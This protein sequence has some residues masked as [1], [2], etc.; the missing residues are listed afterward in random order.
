MCNLESTT[1][2]PVDYLFCALSFRSSFQRLDQWILLRP[3]IVSDQFVEN[4][5]E[6]R[7]II[8]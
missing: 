3:W 4:A 6:L 1:T 8:R 5:G 7:S 2:S